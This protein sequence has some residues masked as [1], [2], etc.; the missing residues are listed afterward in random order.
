MIVRAYQ[1][2]GDMIVGMTG[3][4]VNDAPALKQAEVGIAMGVRGTEVA[5]EA[6][7]VVLLD[8][9][10]RSVVVGI[11]EGRLCADNLKKSIL[12]TLCSKI[13]QL[14]PSL[15]EVLFVPTAL[16]ALQVLLLDLG[17]DI[18]TAMAYAWQPM[19]AEL[20][21]R[22]PKHPR[23]ESMVDCYVLLYS[24]VYMGFLQS[25]MCW[26]LFLLDPGVLPLTEQHKNA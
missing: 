17:T 6:A 20:M 18:W 9:D 26:S 8:D 23:R 4:G 10:L 24:Y 1:Q 11:E 2:L 3:D 16:T 14:L 25:A 19:E 7:D 13:P 12:Y 15:A 21:K 22:N 5:K